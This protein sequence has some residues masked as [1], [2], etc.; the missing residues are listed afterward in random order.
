[1]NLNNKIPHTAVLVKDVLNSFNSIDQNG[2]F[3]DATL[4]YAG[5]SIEILSSNPNLKFI[6]IDKDTTALNFSKNRLLNQKHN[7][8]YYH[9]SFSDIFV[10]FDFNKN[11]VSAILADFGVSS[12]QLDDDKRGFSYNSK[13]LDM[14]MDVTNSL[15]A[16]E[17]INNYK[18]LDLEY[19]FNKYGEVRNY[20]QVVNEIINQRVKKPITTARELAEVVERIS[21]G[22]KRI[23]PATL[24]FQAVRIEVNSELKDIE[25]FLQNIEKKAREKKLQGVIVS[26]ISF[27]SLEDRLVKNYFRNWTK[28]CICD[29]SVIRCECDK[30]NKLGV[31]FNKK[32]IIS[33]KEEISKNPRS[34]S[35]KLRTFIFS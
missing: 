13:F 19:I 31:L 32:P 7:K 15:S 8:I 20:K 35:A 3:I 23:H 1:M 22:K 4:G 11:K 10:D 28:N 6:G 33:S 2:Y 5:H 30:N 9:K 27:H 17:V 25:L 21:Y 24:I 18:K 34:R 14:R 29:N 16:Y 12:L 26:L